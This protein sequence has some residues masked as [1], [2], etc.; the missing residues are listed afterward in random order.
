MTALGYGDLAVRGAF[1]LPDVLT[2]GPHY[3]SKALALRLAVE[4]GQDRSVEE[5]LGVYVSRDTL[6][7]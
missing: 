1:G 6:P 4:L 7:S 3:V 5:R 2:F